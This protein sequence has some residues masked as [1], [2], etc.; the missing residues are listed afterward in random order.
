MSTR[1]KTFKG[2]HKKSAR[3]H[4]CS[5][6]S[7]STSCFLL[8]PP[9]RLAPA[10]A[11]HPPPPPPRPPPPPAPPLPPPTPPLPT[12]PPFPPPLFLLTS[13]SFLVLLLFFRLGH[14]MTCR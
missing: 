9:P 12:P 5:F 2:N 10:P 3:E 1:A 13:S 11:P 4:V 14:D 6:F 7:P 8:L